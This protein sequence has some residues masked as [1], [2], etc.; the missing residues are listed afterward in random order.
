MASRLFFKPLRFPIHFEYSN[1]SLANFIVN[2]RNKRKIWKNRKMEISSTIPTQCFLKNT[3]QFSLVR[4]FKTRQMQIRL[5]LFMKEYFNNTLVYLATG[6]EDLQGQTDHHQMPKDPLEKTQPSLWSPYWR[7]ES[8]LRVR[9]YIQTSRYV[10]NSI[11]NHI[12]EKFIIK[13]LVQSYPNS[14]FIHYV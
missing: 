9:I 10:K 14:H 3:F 12:Y 11:K 1:P 6:A 7:I 2:K 4:Y 13:Y 5:R 8:I